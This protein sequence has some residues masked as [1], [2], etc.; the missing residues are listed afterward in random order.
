MQIE[1]R[2]SQINHKYFLR[3]YAGNIKISEMTQWINYCFMITAEIKRGGEEA[4]QTSLTSIMTLELFFFFFFCYMKSKS[5]KVQ[6]APGLDLY[7]Q[8]FVLWSDSAAAFQIKVLKF[9]LFSKGSLFI[10]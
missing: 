6:G 2:M 5:F 7:S 10:P 1:K 4:G 3:N 9:K 8:N